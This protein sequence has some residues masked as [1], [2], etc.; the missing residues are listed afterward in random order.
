MH[1]SVHYTQS[2]SEHSMYNENA[3]VSPATGRARPKSHVESA[4]GTVVRKATKSEDDDDDA[5]RFGGY[6]RVVSRS[7]VDVASGGKLG[8]T[9]G[10]REVSGKVAEE[11]RGG[12]WLRG[13]LFMRKASGKA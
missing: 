2:E 10:R 7:G 1:G 5:E 9:K 13:G 12:G 8:V 11:G 3:R 4:T 6:T